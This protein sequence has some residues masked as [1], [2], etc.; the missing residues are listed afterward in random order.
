MAAMTRRPNLEDLISL[1]LAAG[2]EIMAVREAGF[3]ASSKVDGS[4][5]TIADQ[6]AEALIEAELARLMPGVPMIGE[7]AHAEGRIPDPGALFFCVDP[8]DGT[9]DFVAGGNEFTANIALVENGVPVMGV[10]LAPASGELYAGEPGRAIKGSFNRDGSPRIALAPIAAAHAKPADGWRVVASRNST[11]NTDTAHFVEALGPHVL[12]HVSSSI[13]LCQ[14]AEGEADLY[15]RFGDVNEWDIAAGH[16]ILSAVGG[17]VMLLDGS[18][19]RYGGRGGSFLVHSF[20]AF[21]NAAAASAARDAM[22]R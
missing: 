5:V 16:A 19:I 18:P 20:I 8:V 15:P 3:E 22:Q 1:T 2:R 21:A 13:K 7:E 9:R 12:K 17:D 14:L 4:L 11:Q 10:V 6:R